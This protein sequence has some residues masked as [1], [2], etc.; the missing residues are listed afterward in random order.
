M[1]DP[2]KR[3]RRL[4]DI[5]TRD[6]WSRARARADAPEQ[7]SPVL[8]APSIGRRVVTIAVAFA[9]FTAAG[10][11][12]FTQFEGAGPAPG[13]SPPAPNETLTDGDPSTELTVTCTDHGASIEG[14]PVKLLS[15]GVHIRI[16]E[17]GG[18]TFFLMRDPERPGR[19]VG[20]DMEDGATTELSIPIEP[21]TWVAT[22]LDA[23]TGTADV[24]LSAF[25]AP[26]EI[27]DP[28]AVW[29]TLHEAGEC[30]EPLP[31]P[32]ATA[33]TDAPLVSSVTGRLTVQA[34]NNDTGEGRAFFVNGDGSDPEPIAPDQPDVSDIELSP[35]GTRIVLVIPDDD[36][37]PT[38]TNASTED[39]EIY[40]MNADGSGLR[41]LTDNRAS[42]DLVR[43]T[44]E[45]RLSFR[46]NRDR[47][48]TLYTMNADGSDARQLLD[49]KSA[50]SHDWSPDGTRLAYIGDAKPVDAGCSFARELF[51]SNADGSDPVAL[52]SDEL[53]Q[54]D[55]A[56][57][58]DASTIAF[59][60]SNQS[61]YAWEIFLVDA[62]GS[63]LRRITSYD[64]YDQNPIWSPDG[65]MIAFT[66]DRFKGPDRRGEDQGGVPYVMNADG[67][68][69][70]ALLEPADLGLEGGWDLYVT[71]WRA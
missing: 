68:G 70:Q 54:Q 46:S 67:S 59:T 36:G 15:D 48:L 27:V 51:V 18:M 19:S 20:F 1:T 4:D 5:E 31:E 61:D 38:V 71:D 8:E 64:G 21:G 44:P 66:S 35:D 42:D 23:A 52:T 26:F 17:E 22:C 40:V 41:R 55:P 30:G 47:A 28:D 43:W 2:K 7:P 60:A 56:W 9:A 10:V 32:L 11:F 58:P 69:A 34:W 49:S 3:L 6:L 50:D 53:Y 14:T 16:A 57:S 24:P 62:D 65:S 63:D 12:L 13:E 39:S 45:G 25:S 29:H 33:G 37:D